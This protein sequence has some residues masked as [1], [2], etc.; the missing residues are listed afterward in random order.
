METN[1]KQ[2][3]TNLRRMDKNV[4]RMLPEILFFLY[5]YLIIFYIRDIRNGTFAILM[6]ANRA[7]KGYSLTKWFL[8]V[9]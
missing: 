3:D 9:L 7:F 2:R 8:I 4:R 6:K 5:S 1:A